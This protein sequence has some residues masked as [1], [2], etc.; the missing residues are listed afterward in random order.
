MKIDQKTLQKQWKTNENWWNTMQKQWKIMKN[1][2]K[3]MKNQWKLMK[4][5]AITMKNYEK[6]MKR[7]G[8]NLLIYHG[9]HVGCDKQIVNL[10]ITGPFGFFEHC[11]LN[12]W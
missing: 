2:A 10:L 12:T 3:T 5:N 9:D 1:I 4:N 7:F 8:S 6:L 11:P